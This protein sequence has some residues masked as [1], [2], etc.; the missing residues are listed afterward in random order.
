MNKAINVESLSSNVTR[1]LSI[2]DET[3]IQGNPTGLHYF[4]ITD[5]TEPPALDN[6]LSIN[7]PMYDN[8]N[9]TFKWIQI[10]YQNTATE[11]LLEIENLKSEN[12]ALRAELT[13]ANDNINMLIEL[14]ADMIGG[15]V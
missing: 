11:E 6:P 13:S 10:Q 12:V 2:A 7:Y 4:A 15:A 8:V 3:I 1:V 5:Y 9:K 14:Q